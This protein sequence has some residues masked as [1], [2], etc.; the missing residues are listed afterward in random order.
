MKQRRIRRISTKDRWKEDLKNV[1]QKSR[2]RER[3]D[4]V[5]MERK[6]FIPAL[7]SHAASDAF[8]VQRG[9]QGGKS[10]N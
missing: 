7:I 8:D 9:M 2:T 5:E 3:L 4:D 6:S 10:L 1:L